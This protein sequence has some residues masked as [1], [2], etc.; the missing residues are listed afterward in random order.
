MLHAEYRIMAKTAFLFPGQGAQ[1]VGMGKDLYE[2]FESA[3]RIFDQ[4][5]QAINMPLKK[6]CFEG[7]EEELNKT[8][9][10]Q[11]AIFT[12]SAAALAAMHEVPGERTDSIHPAFSAGLSLGEYTALYA[13]GAIDFA[14]ALRLVAIRGKLM[15]DAAVA[16]P[17]GMVALLGVEEDGAAK[18]CQAASQGQTL[19]CANFNCP[20]QIVISG[21]IDACRRAE[22][23]A[24]EF[25]AS[26]AVALKV[27]GAFHCKIM[28]P[29]ATIFANVL[30]AMSFRQ[31]KTTVL[32]NV[33]AMPYDPA[34]RIADKLLAQ[35]TGAVRWQQCCQYMISHGV[36]QFYEIG[37]GK[38]LA[39]LMRKI[40]RKACL[41]TINSA[42]AV[43]K[44]AQ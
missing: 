27:A 5:E 28:A 24:K 35:L 15:Q 12:M 40:N 39:G 4:A 34:G 9:I 25:G 17:S 37:P 11:P 7:P 31:P 10:C 19:T 29:A 13:A 26:G 42:E 44:L 41:T 23:M 22:A 1:H 14:D 43:K 18:L 2:A 36:E 30:E 33:D 32:A 38:S 16:T 20:G 6:L 8:D 3:R 21:Q